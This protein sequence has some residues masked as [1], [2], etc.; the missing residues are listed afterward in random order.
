[1]IFLF[2]S[3]AVCVPDLVP[4][5]TCPETKEN[6][7]MYFEIF[8]KKMD[9]HLDSTNGIG[10]CLLLKEVQRQKKNNE[11]NTIVL[12]PPEPFVRT[13]RCAEPT[14]QRHWSNN[15]CSLRT[16]HMSS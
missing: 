13:V 11:Q 8:T 14:L 6:L 2:V 15:L 5:S 10:P 1:M 16:P 7:L 12:V 9:G 3:I 4:V